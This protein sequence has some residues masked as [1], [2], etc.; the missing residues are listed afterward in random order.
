MNG[1]IWGAGGLNIFLGPKRPPSSNFTQN[2]ANS[3]LNH[4]N[5][6][7]ERLE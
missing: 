5:F 7:P 6:W 3:A 1:G 4:A 2:H